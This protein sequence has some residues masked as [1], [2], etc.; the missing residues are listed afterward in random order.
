MAEIDLEELDTDVGPLLVHARDEVITPIIRARGTWERELGEQLRALLRPGMTAVDVGGNIGYVALLMAECVGPSGRVIAVEPDPRNAHVLKLNAAR[1]RGAPIEVIEAAA[2][3]ETT[4]LELRLHATNTGDHRIGLEHGEDRET[5]AVAAVLLDDV[6]PERVD[7]ML[8]DTQA[9]EHVALQGARNLLE[10]SR[11]VLLVEFWPQGLREAGVDPVSVLDG[12]RAMGLEVTGAE[13]E[14]PADPGQLVTAVDAAEVPFTTLRLD[15]IGPPAPARERLLPQ[16]Q[17]LGRTWARRF[18]PTAAPGT[19]AYDAT[20]RALVS[21]VLDSEAWREL[22]AG[23]AQLPAGLAAGFDERVVEYGWLFSRGLRGRVLDA[24]SV[25]NHRH[26]IE[27]LLPA[28]DDLAIV[29]LSP[30]P[31]AFTELGVSHLYDDL[32]QLPLRD[33]WFDE[34]VC[35]STL[36][37]VGMDNTIYGTTAPRA[38]DPRAE[39]GAA[40]RELLRVVR[41]GG[42]VHLSVPSGLSED[43]GWFRQLD[44]DDLSDLLSRAGVEHHEEAV[45]VHASDGWRRTSAERAAAA[46]YND[47]PGRAAD[48]AVA[49]RAVTCITIHG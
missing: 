27:R 19:L 5:V 45:F 24:G 25:L 40:L 12:Y 30:E 48:G 1:T 10:R 20:H 42:R 29:T 16:R 47:A 31:T 23:D 32:R 41:P 11:P 13:G 3:S 18:P 7:L 8:M 21:S 34:V 14:L 44:R 43:H 39:A 38:A 36:E 35:L 17:R 2:W 22:F 37:H 49:A 26:I 28:V 6:L 46:R 9:S 15:P 4:T 33:D